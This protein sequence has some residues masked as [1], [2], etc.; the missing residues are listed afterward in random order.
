MMLSFIVGAM[1]SGQW[2]TRTGRYKDIAIFGAVAMC[3]GLLLMA[4]LT[5]AATWPV[6]AT[7]W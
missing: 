6:V 5:A 1:A 2:M 7:C 4:R 3:A